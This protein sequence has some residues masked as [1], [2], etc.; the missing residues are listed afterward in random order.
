[1]ING[2]NL[3]GLSMVGGGGSAI[4]NP[5]S[6][7]FY[8][9]NLGFTPSSVFGASTGQ[10]LGAPPFTF[11]WLLISGNSHVTVQTP[12]ASGTRFSWDGTNIGVGTL[13]VNYYQLSVIDAAGR[14]GLS[15]VL[16]VSYE[17]YPSTPP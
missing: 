9:D 10:A 1:M 17:M 7:N 13:G 4:L 8:G 11:S 14:S 12:T 16:P 2:L 15:A 6:L 3:L 5:V